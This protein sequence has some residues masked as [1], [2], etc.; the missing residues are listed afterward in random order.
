MLKNRL[1]ALFLAAMMATASFGSAAHAQAPDTIDDLYKVEARSFDEVY[2]LSGADFTPYTKV[3]IDDPEVAFAQNWVQDYNR[4][5]R[6]PGDRID[7]REA[8]RILDAAREDVSEVYAGAFAAAGYEIVTAP[9][10]DVLRVEVSVINITINAP[11]VRSAGR[12]RSY[13]REAGQAKLI[14][15]VRDSESGTLLGRAVD[16]RTIGDWGLT[17]T[18]RTRASNRADFSIAFRRWADLSVKGLDELKAL[19]A[20]ADGE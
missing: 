13:S 16:A 8:R 17:M 6:S 3:M 19:S 2:L 14:L 12:S 15:E 7:G 4:R 18:Q 11:D 20:P 1:F 9:G 5:T 10:P